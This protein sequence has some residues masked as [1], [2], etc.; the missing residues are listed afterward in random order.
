LTRLIHVRGW[1]RDRELLV[2]DRD[3]TTLRVEAFFNAQ[4][5]MVSIRE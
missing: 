5:S 4:F 1:Y 3:D 2:A